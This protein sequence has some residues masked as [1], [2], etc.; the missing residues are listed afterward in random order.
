M[1]GLIVS[2]TGWPGRTWLRVERLRQPGVAHAAPHTALAHTK[3]L[4]DFADVDSIVGGVA[5]VDDQPVVI[6]TTSA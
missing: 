3:Q 4:H 6:V 5:A 1:A 2:S